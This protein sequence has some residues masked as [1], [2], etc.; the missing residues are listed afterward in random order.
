MITANRALA[1]RTGD[2]QARA[3]LLAELLHAA[4]EKPV[5]LRHDSHRAAHFL[6]VLETGAD[7]AFDES[8]FTADGRDLIV[9]PL[10]EG[11]QPGE[12]PSGLRTADGVW[13]ASV[14]MW[15]Y[16]PAADAP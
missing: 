12:L 10:G 14:A 15:R 1:D 11:M 16:R 4:G 7:A 9:L 2:H 13:T 8:S 5:M 3:E 6:V